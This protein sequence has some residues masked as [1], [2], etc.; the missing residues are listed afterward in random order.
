MSKD[1]GRVCSEIPM[2]STII[3]VGPVAYQSL[4]TATLFATNMSSI[5]V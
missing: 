3:L 5:M 4:Q 1:D 2:A